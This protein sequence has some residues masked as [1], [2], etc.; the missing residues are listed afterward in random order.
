MDDEENIAMSSPT[1]RWAA[2]GELQRLAVVQGLIDTSDILEDNLRTKQVIPK[3][4][5]YDQ[6]RASGQW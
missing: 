4:V 2:K 6:F 5:P 1:R 3:E